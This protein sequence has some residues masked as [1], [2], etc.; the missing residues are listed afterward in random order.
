[1]LEIWESVKD[2]TNGRSFE[3]RCWQAMQ[4]HL[5]ASAEFIDLI[6]TISGNITTVF[7]NQGSLSN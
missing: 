4:S 2:L 3:R 6:P 5:V 7:R 1:M